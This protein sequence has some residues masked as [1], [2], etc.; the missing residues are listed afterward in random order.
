MQLN[1]LFPALIQFSVVLI[2]IEATE[3]FLPSVPLEMIGAATSED[4]RLF[5]CNNLIRKDSWRSC[6]PKETTF[7]RLF[8]E[9]VFLRVKRVYFQNE[10]IEAYYNLI[11]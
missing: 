6:L 9:K 3:R 11:F 7:I 2:C 8:A 10:K 1:N 4:I 5:F